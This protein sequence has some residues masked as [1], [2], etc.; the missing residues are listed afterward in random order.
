MLAAKALRRRSTACLPDFVLC[1]AERVGYV[2]ERLI[3]GDRIL[4]NGCMARIEWQVLRLFRQAVFKLPKARQQASSICLNL[5]ALP[6][7][8]KLDRE[9]V[10]LASKAGSAYGGKLVNIFVGSPD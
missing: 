6:T 4:L 3:L 1:R 9:P 2:V 10:N 5:A 7:K 8:P